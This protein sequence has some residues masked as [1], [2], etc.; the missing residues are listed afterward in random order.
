MEKYLKTLKTAKYEPM[1]IGEVAKLIGVKRK[2]LFEYLRNKKIIYK[3]NIPYDN[4]IKKKWM[5]V[6]VHDI[7]K[8]YFKAIKRTPLV[9]IA[10]YRNIKHDILLNH[11]NLIKTLTPDDF[12]YIIQNRIKSELLNIS[13]VLRWNTDEA[14]EQHMRHN[15]MV[16]KDE[17]GDKSVIYYSSRGRIILVKFN[18]EK[19]KIYG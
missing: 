12:W 6:K 2:D 10:G 9:L 18:E 11:S 16:Y 7:N 14:F 15:S 17:F 19:L 13:P 4:F 5:S 3:D 8:D 1:K